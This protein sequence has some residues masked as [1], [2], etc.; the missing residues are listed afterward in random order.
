MTETEQRTSITPDGLVSCS[1][2]G[3]PM[4]W[5]EAARNYTHAGRCSYGRAHRHLELTIHPPNRMPGV[6]AHR[7]EMDAYWKVE[8]LEREARIAKLLPE[9][10]LAAE[11]WAALALSAQADAKLEM[12]IGPVLAL[13]VV[14][15]DELERSIV[16]RRFATRP[17]ARSSDY[18]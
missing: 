13:G 7:W 8:D 5:N 14:A 9:A 12:G 1:D 2:T 11:L 10:C 15:E 18:E 17:H 16:L 3:E 6:D 4:A